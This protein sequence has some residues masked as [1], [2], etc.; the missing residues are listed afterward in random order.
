MQC[1]LC[2]P[3]P[4]VSNYKEIIVSTVL[5]CVSVGTGA[6]VAVVPVDIDRAFDTIIHLQNGEN[7]RWRNI[8]RV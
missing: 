3:L 4:D 2:A 1:S 8:G 6:E 7:W 5:L